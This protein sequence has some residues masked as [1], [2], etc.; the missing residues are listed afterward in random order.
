MGARLNGKPGPEADRRTLEAAAA[1]L[2]EDADRRSRLASSGRQIVRVQWDAGRVVL[3]HLR[4]TFRLGSADGSHADTVER[5]AVRNSRKIAA[6][7]SAWR[8]DSEKRRASGAFG[9]QVLC[10]AWRGGLVVRI[11]FEP[12]IVLKPGTPVDK[13]A[14]AT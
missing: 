12:R 6:L 14:V 4:P 8:E 10:V 9:E 3:A 7:L 13:P 5:R 11:T 2:T 1:W